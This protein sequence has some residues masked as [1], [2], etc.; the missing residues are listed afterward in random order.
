MPGASQA[1]L[2]FDLTPADEIGTAANE[3]TFNAALTNAGSTNL[4][5]NDIQ[6]ELLLS[7]SNSLIVDTNVFYANVPGTL[8]PGETCTDVVFGV[9]LG[10][11]APP[12][13]YTGAISI[14]GGS[15][16]FAES[17]L[18]AVSFQVSLP[19]SVGDGIPDWWRQL[20]F[21]GDGSTTNNLSCAACDADAT[22]QDNQFKFVAGLNP[23]N[24]ASVFTMTLTNPAAPALLFGPVAA[25]RAVMPQFTEDLSL[26]P[27]QA[28]AGPLTAQTNGSQFDITDPNPSTSNRFYRVE[29]YF[30]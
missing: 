22:G 17:N 25:G 6:F 1:Q 13:D 27:W 26:G 15:N 9:N 2:S 29:I 16:I 19:D 24:S 21:G 14:L 18:A 28:L 5:L 10:Q 3:F 7:A 8:L 4:Y 12:G 23:T 20:Y 11:V 30:P